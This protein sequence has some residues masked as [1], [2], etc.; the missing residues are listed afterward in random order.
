MRSDKKPAKHQNKPKKVAVQDPNQQSIRAWERNAEFWDERMGEGNPFHLEL[1]APSTLRFLDVRRG[2]RILDIACGNGLFARRLAKLGADVTAFDASGPM[3]ARA[4][5]HRHEGP[6]KVRYETI[7]ATDGRALLALGEGKFDSAV[8]NM[9][10]MDIADIGPLLHSLA[11]L[12]VPGGRFVF[13]VMHPSF[14]SGGVTLGI[15]EAFR[16]GALHLE[17]AVKVVDYLRER[18]EWGVAL[19]DQPAPQPYFHRTLSTLLTTCFDAGFVLDGVAEPAFPPGR[20]SAQPL[21]WDLFP[22]IPPVLVARLSKR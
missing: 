7:D 5:A 14:N 15:E 10:L 2:Q 20:S 16:D 13:S 18:V 4:R 9:A 17:H 22:L 1:V 11:R 6:G 8:A 21:S 3:I 12:L 19:R